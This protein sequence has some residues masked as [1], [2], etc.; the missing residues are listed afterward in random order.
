MAVSLKYWHQSWKCYFLIKASFNIK[1]H[2]TNYDVHNPPSPEP[3]HP[4]LQ[5]WTVDLLFWNNKI[6]KHVAN[7]KTSPPPLFIDIIN[8]LL[9]E[10][11]CKKKWLEGSDPSKLKSFISFCDQV[12]QMSN[13]LTVLVRDVF[14]NLIKSLWWSVFAETVNDF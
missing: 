8:G 7:F 12:F 10:V 11:F 13:F 9:Q 1:D 14:R 4:H 2:T 6:Y 5:K 3:T